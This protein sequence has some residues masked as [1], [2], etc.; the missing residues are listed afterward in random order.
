MVFSKA[1]CQTLAKTFEQ[2]SMIQ[3]NTIFTNRRFEIIVK[4]LVNTSLFD[5][6][7]FILGS[8]LIVSIKGIQLYVM[9]TL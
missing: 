9:L 4:R 2:Y 8:A 5:Q 3:K 7:G 1:T 6:P